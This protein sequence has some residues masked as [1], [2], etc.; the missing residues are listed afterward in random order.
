M[1]DISPSNLVIDI[2]DS[3]MDLPSSYLDTSTLTIKDRFNMGGNTK[4]LPLKLKFMVQ[5]NKDNH[6][7]VKSRLIDVRCII[8]LPFLEV[9]SSTNLREENRATVMLELH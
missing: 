4:H 9:V 5:F 3:I 7:S 8:L 2:T 1:A 6:L